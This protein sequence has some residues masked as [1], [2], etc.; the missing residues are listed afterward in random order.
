MCG[1]YAL[2]AE[3][4]EILDAFAISTEYA[5]P[6]LPADWNI[7][8]TRDIYIV[9]EKREHA[10]HRMI[11]ELATV[12]W[13]LIAPWSETPQDALRSQSQAI[14][15]RSETVH[16]KPTFRSAFTTRRCLIPA[17]GYYE[18]ATELGPYSPK[19]PFFIHGDGLLAFAGIWDRWRAPDGSYRESAAIIT[20]P[21]VEFLATVHHRMPTFLPADRWSTWLDPALNQVAEI[22]RLMEQSRPAHGLSAYPVSSRVNSTA[23]NGAGLLAKIE[24][25]EPETLF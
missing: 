18:W 6:I 16:E 2:A 24:L 11:R 25:G 13:G 7:T 3:Q 12:S 1:R 19:Q 17:S 10:T 4:D 21:A 23:N 20:R 8:P 22:R 14:N 15:A 9:R 5:G